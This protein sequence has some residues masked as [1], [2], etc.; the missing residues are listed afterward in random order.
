MDLIPGTA[1]LS[2]AASGVMRGFFQQQAA[3][4]A[5]VNLDQIVFWAIT[6]KRSMRWLVDG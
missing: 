1:P 4:V 5:L 2:L 6:P 3:Y